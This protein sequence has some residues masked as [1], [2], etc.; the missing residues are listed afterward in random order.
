MSHICLYV[1]SV[2]NTWAHVVGFP[3][4]ERE[5]KIA[6]AMKVLNDEEIE[7]MRTVGRVRIYFKS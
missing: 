5:A 4:G 6:R 2:D 7:A 1:L 3:A